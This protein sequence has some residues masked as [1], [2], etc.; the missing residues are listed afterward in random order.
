MNLLDVRQIV[1]DHFGVTEAEFCGIGRDKWCVRAR[2]AFVIVGYRNTHA[3]WPEVARAMKP[4]LTIVGHS[5]AL[6]AKKRAE[7]KIEEDMAFRFMEIEPLQAKIDVAK[8]VAPAPKLKMV[9]GAP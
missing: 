6:T 3:S 8:G 2:E 5:G 4:P 1:L 7:K 9:G